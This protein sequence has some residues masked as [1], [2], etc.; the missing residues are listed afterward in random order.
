MG[1]LSVH[2]IFVTKSIL[3]FKIA[4]DLFDVLANNCYLNCVRSFPLTFRSVTVNET[5]KCII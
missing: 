5:S 1:K 3:S 4:H 2:F